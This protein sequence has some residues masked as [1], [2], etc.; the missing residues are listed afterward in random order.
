MLAQ[1]VAEHPEP[2]KTNRK[3]TRLLRE[4]NEILSSVDKGIHISSVHAYLYKTTFQ[5]FSGRTKIMFGDSKIATF[6]INVM[7]IRKREGLKKFRERLTTI[8]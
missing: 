7:T 6:T 1:L 2:E 3:V 8:E 4:L 5:N